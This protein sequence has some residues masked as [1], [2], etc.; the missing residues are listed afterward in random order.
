MEP[1]G[2]AAADTPGLS[3]AE[4]R[5]RLAVH[6]ENAIAAPAAPSPL[7]R[8]VRQFRSPL[9]YIL[10]FALAL[11]L[12]TWAFEGGSG[13]PAGALV[14][15]LVLLLNAGLGVVQEFRS[16]RAL[17]QLRELAAPQAWL[18]RDGRLVRVPSAEIV[19]GDAVRLEAGERVPADGTLAEARGVML[20]ESLLTGESVPVDKGA[21]GGLLSGTLVVRGTGLLE[22]TR[23]GA[24]S[25]MGKLAAL[26]ARLESGQTPL[27]RRLD[28]F[29]DRVARWVL[30]LTGLLVAAGVWAEGATRLPEVLLFAVAVAVSAVPEGMPAVVAL[31]L[32]L[33]VQRMARRRAVVR[34]LQAVEALGSVSVIATDKTGTLT[35]NRLSV[36]ALEAEDEAQALEALVLANDAD[37]VTG[38]GDPLDRALLDFARARGVDPA[39]LRAAVVP[40]AGRPFDSAWKFLRTEAERDGVR[41]SWLKGAA[42]VILARSDL[43]DGAREGWLRRA[44][45]RAAQGYRVLGLATG[46]GDAEAG[47]RFLGLVSLWDPPRPEV[48][49]AVARAQGAGVR[50]VMITGDHPATARAVARSIGMAEAD[51]PVLEGADLARLADAERTLAIRRTGV[52]A[53]VAPEHKLAI[54]EALRADDQVV[55]VTGDGV[56]DALALKRSD[57]GVAMGRRGSDVARECSDLVLL[58]D[59]FASIVAA[60]EEGRGI[61]ANIQRFIRFLFSTNAGELLLIVAGTA[62]AWWLGLRDASGA[63]LVPLTAVQILWINF[64]TDGPPALALGLDRDPSTMDERPRPAGS[65]LLD[66][67]SL[68]FIA[69]SGSFK[70]GVAGVLLVGLPA[71][72]AGLE[73]TRTSV[74]AFTGLAQLAFAYPVRRLGGRPLP[75]RA[76]HACVL[77]G[78]ALQIATVL[79]PGLRGALGL[80]LLPGFAWAAVAAGVALTWLAAEGSIRIAGAEGPPPAAAPGR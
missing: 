29:G 42:E 9:L 8:F 41:T 71:A 80:V 57:V 24:D 26:V 63:L 3:S 37:P 48:K 66:R 23:T 77:L 31:T 36:A 67:A 75:N 46:R 53:R 39:P 61:Y 60:I 74:F 78:G 4:A 12:A 47:L 7:R 44:E 22:V 50:I 43:A 11:D 76:L 28:A 65:P 13:V 62:G 51:G 32:A 34:R 56:N 70:A 49:D 59:D 5:R 58:D 1:A 25:S 79:V 68:R 54:V 16:E 38:V 35:E 14:I 6:G 69:L 40:D 17:A 2:S 72:G 55:A 20:D 19:P 52:F 64:I 15:G 33:G 10:L 21:G 30:V 73:V 27:E 45:A 18:L